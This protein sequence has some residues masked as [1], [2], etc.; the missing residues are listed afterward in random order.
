MALREEVDYLRRHSQQLERANEDLKKDI[1]D[2]KS[3]L[4]EL[5]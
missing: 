2:I 5:D 3:C 1:S 4:L